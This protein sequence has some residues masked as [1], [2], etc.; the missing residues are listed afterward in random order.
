[1]DGGLTPELAGRFEQHEIEH[2]YRKYG[3]HKYSL[4]DFGLTE[5]DI[6]DHTRHYQEFIK[7]IH[8]RN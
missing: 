2:P 8:E 6:D 4:G 3:T 1:M 5:R 7:T